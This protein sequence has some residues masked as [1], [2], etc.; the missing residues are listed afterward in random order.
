MSEQTSNNKHTY[1]RGIAIGLLVGLTLVLVF[2]FWSRMAGLRHVE[3]DSAVLLLRNTPRPVMT[4]IFSGDVTV[5]AGKYQS[6]TINVDPGSMQNV[7]VWGSFHASG[8]S[9]NDIQAVVAE[10]SEFENWINGHEAKVHYSTGKVTNGQFNV[11]LNQGGT[12]ILAFSNTYSTF[13]DK[14][15][16]AEVKIRYMVP[17]LVRGP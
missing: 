13:T 12:Y 16:S 8:G 10:Q 1:G 17:P 4:T 14:D 6:W 5:K 2:L 9:G 15:V 7:H 3:E 11:W